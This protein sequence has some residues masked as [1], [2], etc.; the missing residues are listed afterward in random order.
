M[1]T[2]VPEPAGG[3][4]AFGA[5]VAFTVVLVLAPQEF[6]PVLGQVRI[7]FILATVAIAAHMVGGSKSTPNSSTP[8]EFTI[9]FCLVVW[10][11]A[12][13]P[14]SYWPGGS[15]TTL[16]DQYLK[17]IAIFWL[18]GRVVCSTR[19]LQSLSWT[20]AAVSIPIAVVG[21]KNYAAGAFVQGRVIGYAG[22]LTANPNDLALTLNLFNPLT[23]AVALTA[24]R[25]WLRA[26]AWG[27]IGLNTAA[28]MMTFSRAGFLTLI[29]EGGLLLLLLVR[30]R[31]VKA[32]R[33]LA[34]CAALALVTLPSGY[35]QRLSTIADIDSD[36][37]GSAQERW[38]DTK[39]A[40]QFIIAHPIIGA[41]V[42]QGLLALNELRGA[43][44]LPV[45]NVYLAYGVDLGVPGLLLF[46]ALVATS[47]RSARRIERALVE[48]VGLELQTFA[49]GIRISLAGFMVAAFFHPVPYHFYFYYIAGLAVALK[50]IAARRPEP[51][52]ISHDAQD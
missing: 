37:T 10:A 32:A 52:L 22:G 33:A 42:G 31:A 48:T 27:I 15:L 23:A 29:T 12:S 13:I 30:R 17:S 26:L 20:L 1:E 16:T 3:R 7:A 18:L 9:A 45:H 28:V 21:L 19:R 47:F 51:I 14:G 11:V 38:R 2:P 6:F 44:W 46:V 49:S 35:G 43:F 41:G 8:P 24:R 5:L 40:A 25:P 50:T 39:V 36:P 4:L 34:L